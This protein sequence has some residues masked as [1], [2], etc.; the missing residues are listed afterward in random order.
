MLE[1]SILLQSVRQRYLWL[2]HIVQLFAQWFTAL[3]EGKAQKN[4][5]PALDGVRAIACLT[6]VTFHISLITKQDIHIW[7]S[8]NVNPLI[9]AIALSGDT[10][11][12]L[13]FILSGFLLFLPYA[14]SLLFAGTQWPS[15]RRFYLRRALRILPAYYLTLVLMVLIYRP[16]YRQL[17]HLRN[18]GFFLTLFM[19]SSQSTYKSINGP[20]WT[21]AVEWQ[22]YLLLPILARSEEH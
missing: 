1:E 7:D 2:Q 15:T 18:W 9:A 21:L 17:D 12:T 22:F 10:G 11:V 6:V 5:I 13:F 20:F 16:E 3:L 4:T 19:D 14:K 8:A